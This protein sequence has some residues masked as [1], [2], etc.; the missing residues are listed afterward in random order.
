MRKV[1]VNSTIEGDAGD[2]IS[3]ALSTAVFEM[4]VDGKVASSL[5]TP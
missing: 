3:D 4:N 5:R 1:E 2:R